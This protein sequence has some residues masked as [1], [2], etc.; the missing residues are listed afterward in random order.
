MNPAAR[1]LVAPISAPGA[2][3]PRLT[4]TGRVVLR[5]RRLAL[6][7]EGPNKLATLAKALEDGPLEDMP[8][9]AVLRQAADRLTIFEGAA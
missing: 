7:I 9:R 2:V 5:A 3:E 6:Q 8:I 1:A 4:L